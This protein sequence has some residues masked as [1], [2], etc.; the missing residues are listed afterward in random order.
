MIRWEEPTAGEIV[1]CRFPDHISARPKPR[2][3]LVIAVFD[4]G[5]P[6]FA[7]YGTSQRTTALRRGEFVILQE[8]NP[9]AYRAA[10]LSYG[11]KFDLRQ[12]VILP[13][14]TEWFH[15]PPAAPHGQKPL[16]ALRDPAL[17][18]AGRNTN[19]A[20]IAPSDDAAMPTSNTP[21]CAAV[22]RSA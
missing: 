14:S 5:A 2:P 4:D 19:C 10:G 17:Q 15:V 22:F 13:Y 18:R 9:A 16:V 20:V 12:T 11:T 1:W 6:E 21:G 8:R 3:A 7:A